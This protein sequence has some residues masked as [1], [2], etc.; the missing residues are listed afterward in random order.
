MGILGNTSLEIVASSPD[1]RA[2]FV[3]LGARIAALRKAQSI[4]QVDLA[5]SLGVSQ[6]TINSF[7]TGRR[8]VLVSTLPPLARTLWV[9]IEELIGE[10][11]SAAT[12]KRGPAPKLM[13]QMEGIQQLPR[14]PQR[15]IMRMLDTVLAQQPRQ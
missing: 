15:F 14:T 1:E 3:Q 2:F 6:Q 13:Q 10:P 4:T 12:R 8:R 7:E 9:S 11:P 5:Q